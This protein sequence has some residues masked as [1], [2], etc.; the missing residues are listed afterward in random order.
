M[1]KWNE[2]FWELKISARFLIKLENINSFQKESRCVN[3]KHVWQ[4]S[5]TG[6]Q[7]CLV[8][9][10]TGQGGE[11]GCSWFWKIFISTQKIGCNS[12]FKIK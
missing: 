5:C 1:K 10:Q 2:F 12:N 8:I 6:R 9:F 3:G 7:G 11:G 4:L